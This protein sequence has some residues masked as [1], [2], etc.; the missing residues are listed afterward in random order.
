[1]IRGKRPVEVVE[2]S[3]KK[4]VVFQFQINQKTSSV[5]AIPVTLTAPNAIGPFEEQLVVKIADRP[6]PIVIKARGKIVEQL[7]AQP[8]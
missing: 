3:H 5:H 6:E 1:M 2:I 7:N 4:Q 8:R